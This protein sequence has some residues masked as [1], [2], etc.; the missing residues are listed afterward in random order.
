MKNG[1][2]IYYNRVF[3][4]TGKDEEMSSRIKK[5]QE[6]KNS[7][8]ENTALIMGIFALVVLCVF[9]LVF[10]RY[11]FDILETKYQ[12]YCAA[13]IIMIVIM[14]AYG[15]GSGR[16]LDFLK[17]MK[18]KEICRS[19]NFVDWAMLAFWLSNVLS[20]VFC[21]DWR[22]EA[23]WGTSGRYNG[24]FLMTIY[25]IVYFMVTRFFTFRQ[26]YL[27]A[28]LAVGI[29]VCVFGITD[30]FQM[31]ILG[32]KARMVEEQKSIYTS[33]LG[34]INTYTIYVGAVMVIS[35]ILFALERNQKRMLWY[36]GN[37]V[38]SSFALI[39]GTSDNAYLT[40][41]ALFGLSPLYLFK[42][43]TGVRRYLIAVA[44]FFTVIQCISWIN[45][46]YADTVWGIDSAFSLIAGLSILPAIVVG[47]WVVAGGYAAATLR[48][49]KENKP[50]EMGKWLSYVW[51]GLIAVVILA[52]AYVL[53]DANI[54]GN[55]DKYDA[56]RSYAVFDD[57][58]GT[59]RGYVWRRS[60]E[61]YNTK[62]NVLQRIFGYGSDTFKLIMQLYYDGRKIGDQLIVFDS[63]HNEYLHY[64]ITI[65]IVGVVSYVAFMGG[66]VVKMWKNMKGRPEVAAV[67]FAIVA[68]MVQA[69]VNIN[70]PIAMPIIL[71]LLAM[72]VSKVS[73]GE[74][75]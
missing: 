8:Q 40:L 45:I 25:M 44:T 19:L 21:F 30:Y 31:D 55:A 36:Y 72:G 52:V 4:T 50:E 57:N 69:I 42:T 37:M 41:A 75:D 12:F 64:L 26:W 33:T 43:K 1:T 65:G 6:V 49:K 71:Q 16:L 27:D 2:V 32:F 13:A 67:M 56:I 58:W 11:Y 63:A 18:I 15:L 10:H 51:I 34:N 60:I 3:M 59:G 53:F 22:W 54:A 73:A 24:V 48:G 39:M 66:A 46:A 23:F 20:W 62:F 28:F 9:P 70:L 5:K 61:I 29:F 68:Y 38:L 74:K 35:M 17:T 14:A 47:L 7:F